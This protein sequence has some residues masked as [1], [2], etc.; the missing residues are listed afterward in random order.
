MW[1]CRAVPLLPASP[2]LPRYSMGAGRVAVRLHRYP[3]LHPAGQEASNAGALSA[4]Q[5]PH[6]PQRPG[7]GAQT[8][9]R[10]WTR[11]RCAACQSASLALAARMALRR[12]S[13]SVG[14]AWRRTIPWLT[15][16]LM[17]RLRWTLQR[18]R[19]PAPATQCLAWKPPPSSPPGVRYA[20]PGAAMPAT[21][22]KSSGQPRQSQWGP[23]PGRGSTAACTVTGRQAAVGRVLCHAEGGA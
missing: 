10:V 7:T 15:A 12:D 21:L 23:R 6:R 2:P 1:R 4:T 9:Q 3:P 13:S 20:V 5:P 11:L 17:W 22:H 14:A 18:P 19:C 16:M 8:A